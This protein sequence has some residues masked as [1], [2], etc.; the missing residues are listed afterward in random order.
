MSLFMSP[1]PRAGFKEMPPVS[2]V[3]PFPTRA[4]FFVAFAGEYS[5]FTSRGWRVEPLPTPMM[6]PKPSFSRRFSS[7]TVTL[8]GRPL[9]SSFAASAKDSG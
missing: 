8:M 1:M 7:Q 9:A 3:I 5:T 6:P 2:K 4:I